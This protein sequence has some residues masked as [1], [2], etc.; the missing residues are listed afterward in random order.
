MAQNNDDKLVPRV[1]DIV[2]VYNMHSPST[3]PLAAFV[4]GGVREWTVFAVPL[5]IFQSGSYAPIGYVQDHNPDAFTL[6]TLP[7]RA[8]HD[9]ANHGPLAWDWKER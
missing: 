7:K 6:G 1:G 2:L 8:F 9:I 5:A 4:I 3:P